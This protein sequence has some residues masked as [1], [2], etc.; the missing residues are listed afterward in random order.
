MSVVNTKK[1]KEML[2]LEKKEYCEWCWYYDYGDCDKC[3]LKGV[4]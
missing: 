4:K 3:A 2:P 1:A